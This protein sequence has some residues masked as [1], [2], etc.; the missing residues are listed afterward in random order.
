[1]NVVFACREVNDLYLVLSQA[2]E[3]LP[4][5]D[6]AETAVAR[7]PRGAGVLILADDY[8]GPGPVVTETLLRSAADRGLRLYVEYPASMPALDLGEPTR[9]AWERLV[10]ASDFFRPGLEPMTI[11]A[12]HGCWFLPTRVPVASTHVVAARVA[13]YRR[14]VYG[15]PDGVVPVLFERAGA[16]VL[17][18]TTKLSGF[19]TGR[20]GPRGAWASLWKRLLAWLARGD[21]VPDLEWESTV[22]PAFDRDDALPADVESVALRRS[23]DWFNRHVVYRIDRKVGAIEGYESAI[24]HEGR[25]RPRP[26]PRGDCTAETGMVFAWDWTV[27]GSPASRETAREL[28]D[29]VWSSPDFHQDDPASPAY[30]LNNWFERGPVF[31]GDDNARVI[32]PSLAVARLLDTDRWDERILRCLLANLRTTGP[33]GFRWSRIE[34]ED[35]HKDNRGWRYFRNTDVIHL[36]PHYQGYLWAAFLWAYALTGHDDFLGRPRTAIR[37][38]MEH[39]PRWKWTNGMTQELARMLLPLALLVRVDDTSE[40]RGWLSRVADDLVALMR[41]SGAILERMGEWADGRYPAPRSNEAYGTAEAAI[42]QE[43]GDPCCDLLYTVP[44]ALVG[45]HEAWAATGNAKYVAAAD[46]LAAFV[47]RVQVTSC[48]HPYLDGAWMRGFDDDLWEYWGSSADFGW[49]AWSVESGWTNAW[50]ASVLAMR[51]LGVTLFDTSLAP[52]LRR[53]FP[54]LLR[55]MFEDRPLTRPGEASP[56]AGPVPGSEQTP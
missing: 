56:S 46:R 27:T 36:A 17:V 53:R 22:A 39:Y 16:D 23:V 50:I 21:D 49:G 55:E 41:P 47:S 6:D 3:D 20:Y 12:Q 40:H 7:A 19:V 5:Y 52:R 34:L 48:E 51:R 54:Q 13:G 44:W 15:L 24:D 35:F 33:N 4:R 2:G 28:I 10:V 25:Q 32:M 29:T 8:P 1:M 26:W 9:T 30:G 31:Y 37:I 38:A 14:A 42:I 43:N 45:L 18:S 11:L